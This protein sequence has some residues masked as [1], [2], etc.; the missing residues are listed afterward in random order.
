MTVTAT[1]QPKTAPDR[2]GSCPTC[3]STLPL[4]PVVPVRDRD[5]RAARRRAAWQVAKAVPGGSRPFFVVYDDP[6]GKVS[7]ASL[8]PGPAQ[9]RLLAVLSAAARD[10]FGPSPKTAEEAEQASRS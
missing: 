2:T 9:A 7:C 5:S 6:D 3:G 10:A 8:L 1:A 4:L